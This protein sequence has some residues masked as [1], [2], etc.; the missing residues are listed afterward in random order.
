MESLIRDKN[1]ALD[2][3]DK[4][5]GRVET[6]D[7][8]TQPCPTHIATSLARDTNTP[9]GLHQPRLSNTTGH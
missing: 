9:T 7:R 2:Q 6:A 3:L 1:S 5:S 4:V 8:C